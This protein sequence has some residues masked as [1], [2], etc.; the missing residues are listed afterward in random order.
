MHKTLLENQSIEVSE[1]EYKIV[2]KTLS[3]DNSSDVH[4]NV[5]TEL[6]DDEHKEL[7][8]D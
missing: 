6:R 7:F 3:H 1:S 5:I 4:T 2:H 8:S